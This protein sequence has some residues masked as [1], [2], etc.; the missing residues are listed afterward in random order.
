[1]AGGIGGVMQKTKIVGYMIIAVAV[2]NTAI[3][4]LN[5]GGFDFIT[6]VKDLDAALTGAGLVFLR[7]AIHKL[8][9]AK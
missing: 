6:H 4:A 7:D 5:G 3:D 2:L 1:M 9:L 8:N